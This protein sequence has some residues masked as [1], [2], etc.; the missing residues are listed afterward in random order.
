MKRAFAIGFCL[1]LSSL[2]PAVADVL[3]CSVFD[4]AAAPGQVLSFTGSGAFLGAIDLPPGQSIS[5]PGGVTVGSNGD[6]YVLDV[7]TQSPYT[8]S[9]LEYSPSGGY[10]GVLASTLA[11]AG[12]IVVGPNGNLFVGGGYVNGGRGT[13]VEQYN[14][15]TGA[16]LGAFTQGG[17]LDLPSGFAFAPNGDLYAVS[18]QTNQL[19]L[20]SSTGAYL[21]VYGNL[22]AGDVDANGVAVGPNGLVYVAANALNEIEVFNGTSSSPSAVLA[23]A[24]PDDLVFGP[25]GTLYVSQD[26]PYRVQGDI[27]SYNGSSFDTFIPAGSGGMDHPQ[28]FAFTPVPEP[29][30]ALLVVCMLVASGS[31]LW[32][33]KRLKFESM[34]R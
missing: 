3:V 5:N 20:Y 30:S 4:L 24:Y 15:T 33:F 9:I 17:P 6:I 10:L 22:G 23:V 18:N 11:G 19:L 7:Q 34:G 28:F 21:G 1:L 31:L 26:A 13:V 32:L 29:S 25:G 8:S 16:D 27:L 2:S 12:D 14:S